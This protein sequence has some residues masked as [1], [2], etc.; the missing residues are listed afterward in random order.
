MARP[1]GPKETERSMRSR[2][3]RG[4]GRALAWLPAVAAMCALAFAA[5]AQPPAQ[6]PVF[7]TNVSLVRAVATVKNQAGELVGSLKKEDF[8]IYD[9]GV[10]QDVSVFERQTEQP[11]SIVL[12]LDVSGSTNKDLKYETDS[13]SRFLRKLLSE[14]NPADKASLY[15]VESDVHVLR[16]FTHDYAS[17]E[18]Q[19]RYLHGSGAT[20]LYDAVKWASGDLENR[21]GRKAIIVLTDGDDTISHVTAQQALRAAHLADAVIYPIVVVPITNEA[22]RNIGGEHVLEYMAQGTGGKK[23]MPSVGRALDDAFSDIL[24][25]LRTQYLLGFYPRGAPISREPFHR[26]QVRVSRPE[27]QVSARNGYYGEVETGESAPAEPRVT[28]G[29]ARPAPAA[30]KKK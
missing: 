30:V 19:F 17:L 8:E 21:S 5:L 14:G 12:M 25:E 22:G 18:A 13:A 15:A 9:N 7:K 1:A 16:G 27:L 6:Q 2:A 3:R 28:P 4:R 11:L 24:A 20:A 29:T 10:K 23:F 26:L